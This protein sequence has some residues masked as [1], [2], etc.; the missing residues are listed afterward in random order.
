MS[1]ENILLDTTITIIDKES[2]EKFGQLRYIVRDSEAEIFDTYMFPEYRR[3][4][5]MSSLL[6][7][8]I[9]ELKVSGVSKISLKY[10]DDSARISWEKM[11]FV[12]S[13]KN[14]RMELYL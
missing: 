7:K 9:P 8:I 14:D 11:G 1:L 2:G 12:Q 6:R 3:Q 4:K 5:M 10:F 13:G